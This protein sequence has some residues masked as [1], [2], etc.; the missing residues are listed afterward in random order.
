LRLGPEFVKL[1][2]HFTMNC[3]LVDDNPDFLASAARLLELEGVHVIGRASNGEEALRLADPLAPPDV[4]LVDIE[5]GEE[6]GIDLA[7][8]LAARLPDTPVILISAHD[9]EEL[10]ELMPGAGVVGF[11]PKQ[12]LGA[13]TIT[14]L[15]R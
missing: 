13:A 14:E 8:Q 10:E 12:E 6:N 11:V 5:L 9:R 2:P 3:V 4:I 1:P 15:I 7:R